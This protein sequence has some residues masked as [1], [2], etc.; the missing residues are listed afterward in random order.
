MRVYELI[1]ALQKG[2]EQGMIDELMQVELVADT[3]QTTARVGLLAVQ[4]SGQQV[5]LFGTALP[6]SPGG[7]S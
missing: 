3:E 7:G 6:T 1:E 2:I 5:Q 4:R